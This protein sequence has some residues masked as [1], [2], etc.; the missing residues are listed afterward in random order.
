VEPEVEF[1]DAREK[2]HKSVLGKITEVIDCHELAAKLAN[3]IKNVGGIVRQKDIE[4]YAQGYTSHS[5][6]FAHDI[7]GFLIVGIPPPS[8]G[9]ANNTVDWMIDAARSICIRSCQNTLKTI[10][11]TY[12]KRI[13]LLF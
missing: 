2:G 7:S 3:D 10:K 12:M 6:C 1:I 8:L 13:R 5:C 11:E 9:G 4:S